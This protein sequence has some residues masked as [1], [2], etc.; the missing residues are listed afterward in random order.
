M[1]NSK[2]LDCGLDFGGFPKRITSPTHLHSSWT[3][4][5]VLLLLLLLHYSMP[6]EIQF[7]QQLK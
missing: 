2:L 4:P 5:L 1:D 7:E 3:L 6:I